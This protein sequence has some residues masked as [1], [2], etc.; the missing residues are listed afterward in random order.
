V[1]ATDLSGDTLAFQ[2]ARVR[3]Q[4]H[5]AVFTP[6]SAIDLT[7]LWTFASAFR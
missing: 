5:I 6:R 1:L 4:P 3:A 7:G 2:R